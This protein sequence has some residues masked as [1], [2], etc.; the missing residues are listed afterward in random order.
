MEPNTLGNGTINLGKEMDEEFRSGLMAAG[1]K[2]TGKGIRLM[3]GG[4]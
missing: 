2:D 4:D 1:M 3:G